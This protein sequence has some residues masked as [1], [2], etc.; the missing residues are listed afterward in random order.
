MAVSEPGD[1]SA[2]H[3]LLKRFSGK[4]LHEFAASGV[5]VI[6]GQLKGLVAEDNQAF[7]RLSA[8]SLGGGEDPDTAW[9]NTHNCMGVLR[10]RDPESGCAVQLEIRSRFDDSSSQLFLSYVLGKVFGGSLVEDVQIGPKSMWDV[11]LAFVFRHRL[12]EACRVGLFAQYETFAHNDLRFQGK[13][14]IDEHLRRNVPFQGRVAYATNEL[15]FDNPINHLVRHAIGKVNCKW[16]PMLSGDKELTDLCHEFAE[17]TPSWER[18]RMLACIRANVRPVT[19]PYFHAYYEPLRRV[20]L[21]ILHDEGANLYCAENEAEGVLFDGS[22]LWENYLW[23]ILR[24]LGFEHTDNGTGAGVWRVLGSKFYPDFFMNSAVHPRVVL[25]AKYKREPRCQSDLSQVFAYMYI[26][27]AG[28]GGLIRPV[29]SSDAAHDIVWSGEPSRPRGHWYDLGFQIP[30]GE[31]LATDTFRM[32][33]AE[34]E[35]KLAE[36]VK[37]CLVKPAG[38]P[39]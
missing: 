18:A 37:K 19:H 32:A 35:K 11:L 34:S 6:P 7:S 4:P 23:E 12:L 10:L 38:E 29:E 8:F 25:D 28:V 3:K 31:A 33:M 39:T 22:W 9:I 27:E 24:P 26:L 14:D 15:T 2:V 20:A 1:R 21:E 17:N 36:A 13:F 16:P 30:Q 5:A